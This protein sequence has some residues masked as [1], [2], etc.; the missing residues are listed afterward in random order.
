[1]SVTATDDLLSLEL[2]AAKPLA[3]AFLNLV[4]PTLNRLFCLPE[5]N[6]IYRQV[7]TPGDTLAFIDRVL[8]H[9]GIQIDVDPGDLARIPASGPLLVAANHPFGA[10]E[11][12]VL[13]RILGRVRPDARLLANSLLT[14]IPEMRPAIVGVDPFGR[15]DS[16]A[17]N[18]APLKAAIRWLK[19]G[20]CLGV[21]PAGEVSA[22]SLKTRRIADK[23]W[24]PT[25][26]G[27]IRAANCP[28]LPL[29]FQGAN[30]ALFHLLGLIHP[31]LRTALLPREFLNKREARIGLTMGNVIPAARLAACETD[32]ERIDYVRLRT[33]ALGNRSPAAAKPAPAKTRAAIAPVEPAELLAAELAALAPDKRLVETDEHL[34][35]CAK[36]GD[37]P[38][39]LREI[40]RQREIAF[41]EVGEGTGRPLDL[42]RFDAHYLHLG[43]WH[44]KNREIAGA[45][46][47]GPTDA[48][49][50][51]HGR[52]GLYVNSLFALKPG[53]LDRVTPGIEL[54]RS[55]IRQS[56]QK[57]YTGLLLLWKGIAR[58]VAANPRY[59]VLF[60][61]VSISGDYQ[62][63]SRELLVRV[64]GA[65]TTGE[66]LKRTVRPR[67]PPK[68]VPLPLARAEIKSARTILRDIDDLAA[69]ISDVETDGKGLPVLLRHYLKLGGRILAFNVDSD[70][71][72][73]L[74]G[75]IYVDL[76]RTDTRV[77]SKF[78]GKA[79]AQT[80]L[81]HHAL[82]DPP[83]AANG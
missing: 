42:D 17:R 41:R 68:L 9:F 30:R 8:D 16:Q 23:P 14:L 34:V 57:S 58:Y 37:I 38:H 43:L 25:V 66:G 18:I 10:L 81:A 76:T 49:L 27:I 47:L 13:A 26:G 48:I 72:D 67:T 60:G 2:P 35:F 44:K 32:A 50:S 21:F 6:A 59:G 36:A 54:G 70:F 82:I 83:L 24:S 56:Y 79:E 11:G 12:L 53:F 75:L 39:T 40:G 7:S 19:S 46:R 45:Y 78:M 3:R 4:R 15:L 51:A 1:M 22:F 73:C 64:L 28:V 31:R 74:D 33:Y 63:F 69:L 65:Q 77:L 55:F 62:Q 71:A 29:Y 80:F 20:G 5:L 52:Q 61:P